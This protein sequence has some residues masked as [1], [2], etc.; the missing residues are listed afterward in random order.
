M[1]HFLRTYKNTNL[2]WIQVDMHSHLLPGLD[3]G[4]KT[5][6]DSVGYIKGLYELGFKKLITTPHVFKEVYPNDS[7]SIQAALQAVK[8]LPAIQQLGIIL[9]AAAEYMLDQNFEELVKKGEL[10]SLPGKHV[11]IEMSY[12]AETQS[13]EQSVFDLRIKGYQP[14]LAHPERY[15]FY[16]TNFGRY[17]RLIDL[18]CLMQMNLLSPSGYYGKEVKHAA[19]RLIDHGMVDFLGTDLHHEGHLE[20]LQK[21]VKTGKLY[22]YF[23]GY[24]LKNNTLVIPKV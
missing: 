1:F 2:E 12:A 18:G 22:D 23:G 7:A 24:T 20:A 10:L 14:V 13:I 4:A 8:A 6:E 17:R 11:L 16:H 15:A 9:E 19:L 21:Y 5:P 3:D